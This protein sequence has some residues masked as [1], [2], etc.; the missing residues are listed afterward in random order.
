MTIRTVTTYRKEGRR[1][2]LRFGKWEP[3]AYFVKSME[4]GYSG[5]PG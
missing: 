4:F 5:R 2:V 3:T 1:D